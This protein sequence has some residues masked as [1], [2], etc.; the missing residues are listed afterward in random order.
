MKIY[1]DE[2]LASGLLVRLLQKAGHD[3]E[4]PLGTGL[5][6]RSDPVQFTYAIHES[7]VCLTANY[8]HYEELHLLVR[9]AN[10]DY[11]DAMHMDMF[12]SLCKRSG[13]LFQSSEIY[14][15]AHRVARR[16]LPDLSRLRL[17]SMVRKEAFW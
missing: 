17:A 7:R 14:R 5:L 12:V 15:G 3:V 2:D 8:R 16:G 6:G 1:I 13:Y 10:G 11:A 4:A 9:E